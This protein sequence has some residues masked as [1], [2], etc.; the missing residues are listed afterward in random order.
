MIEVQC[1]R[2]IIS[3]VATAL[4]VKME[5]VFLSNGY[6][7][8][9]TNNGLMFYNESANQ[10]EDSN[11]SIMN[12]ILGKFRIEKVPFTPKVGEDY[13]FVDIFS[14]TKGHG[15]KPFFEFTVNLCKWNDSL[16]DLFNYH[17]NNVF[18]TQEEC[19]DNIPLLSKRFLEI[20]ECFCKVRGRW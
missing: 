1:G 10:W 3:N 2:N 6:K 17:F 4:G 18:S 15:G 7:F 14:L 5:E 19:K 9:F 16:F 11:N 20:Y 13:Y 12:F 8:K